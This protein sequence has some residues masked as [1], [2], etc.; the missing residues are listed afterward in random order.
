M[1]ASVAGGSSTLPDAVRVDRSPEALERWSVAGR[2][3]SAVVFPRSVDEL[4]DV[5]ERASRQGWNVVAAGAGTW[6]DGGGPPDAV[7]LVVSTRELREIREYEPDDLTLTAEAG[8]SL[9]Q[10]AQRTAEHGQWLAQD[11][12]GSPASTL[13]AFVATGLPG[14]LVAGYGRPRDQLLGL[15]AVTGDGR[16]VRPGG[17]VVK[18]VAGFDLVRPLA[19][20]WGTLAVIAAVSV[21]LHPLPERDVTLVYTAPD[22]AALVERARSVATAPVVPAAVELLDPAPPAV[23][24][25]EPRAAA[26]VVR[27]LG[28]SPEVAGAVELLPGSSDADVRLEGPDS[29]AL[30]AGPRAGGATAGPDPTAAADA[31]GAAAP[32]AARRA[33]AP[34]DAASPG[35][36]VPAGE[37]AT[38][39][40]AG[41]HTGSAGVLVVRLALLPDRLETLVETAE[42]LAARA[43]AAEWPV[44]SATH[45][46]RGVLRL[47][48]RTAE[49]GA[50]GE[51]A[52]ED[53]A[54]GRNRWDDWIAALTEVRARLEE[55]GGTVTLAAG[56]RRL[57]EAVGPTGGA[58]GAEELVRGLKR[59]FDP[60]GV[61]A[62]GRWG[63]GGAR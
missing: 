52:A 36:A 53:G 46:T 51:G 26:L 10:L 44:R 8:V 58:G 3:P 20:S 50:E 47:E 22:A 60:A 17:R 34:E 57:V 59:T 37:A 2:R 18:N 35:Q 32:G 55:A 56:P 62:P 30:H 6:L 31:G 16:I 43:R 23:R 42:A 45:V 28:S 13:G 4:A 9:G 48:I 21:R 39:S 7:D 40:R 15:T 41:A 29:K 25:G 54:A 19:G 61:L 38:A 33:G 1:S 63:V 14:P 5:L 49:D 24:A 12:P 11:P 27:V